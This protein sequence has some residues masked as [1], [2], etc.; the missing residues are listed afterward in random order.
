MQQPLGVAPDE[1]S[2]VNLHHLSTSLI[3]IIPFGIMVVAT[4]CIYLCRPRLSIERSVEVEPNDQA[5][6]KRNMVE[7]L[8]CVRSSMESVSKTI[9]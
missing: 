5:Q 4:L 1:T 9:L 7:R 3:L 6:L 8:S 2:F